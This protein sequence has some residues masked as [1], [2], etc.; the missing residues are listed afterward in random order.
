[1][2]FELAL[3]NLPGADRTALD[4]FSVATV[5]ALD[6]VDDV[7]AVPQALAATRHGAAER[8]SVLASFAGADSNTRTT[9]LGRQLRRLAPDQVDSAI[10]ISLK[11]DD[12]WLR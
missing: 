9:S 5:P 7:A 2:R 8:D 10:A 12:N 4:A 11:D 1:V 3:D 6:V